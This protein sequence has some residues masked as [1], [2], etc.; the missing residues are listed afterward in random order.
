MFPLSPTAQPR[1]SPRRPLRRLSSQSRSP[2][3]RSPHH[4]TLTPSPLLKLL[5]A[6]RPLQ[7]RKPPR[8]ILHLTLNHLMRS[9]SRRPQLRRLLRR[10]LPPTLIHPRVRSQLRKLQSRRLPK[11]IHLDLIQTLIS[12]PQR[13]LP[14]RIIALV[15]APTLR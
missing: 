11:K 9:K 14:R 4:L 1:T 2:R 15:P 12:Q 8:R 5:R 13:R 7:Q 6:K 10:T 3:L